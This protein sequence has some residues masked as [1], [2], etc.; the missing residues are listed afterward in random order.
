LE[1]EGKVAI[2]KEQQ[3]L[4]TRICEALKNK[5]II[6]ILAI[7]QPQ[8]GKTGCMFAT[9]KTYANDP[10]N[11]IPIENIHLI[12][13]LSSNDWVKQTQKRFP[14]MLEKNIYHRND[15]ASFVEKIR[16]K[17]NVLIIMDEVQVAAGDKQTLHK[18]FE[19]LGFLDKTTLFERDIKIVEFTAT[20]D[21]TIYDLMKW[22]DASYIEVADKCQGYMSGY[23][24]LN[25]RDVSSDK[26]LLLQE[27]ISNLIQEIA[28]RIKNGIEQKELDILN[29]KLVILQESER[30]SIRTRNGVRV[31]QFENLWGYDETTLEITENSFNAIRELK[32]DIDSFEEARFHIVRTPTKHPDAIDNFKK[33]FPAETYEFVHYDSK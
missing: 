13:G 21:G 31:K 8:S 5:S 23:D 22:G 18:T 19:S 1:E 26:I 7:A 28:N 33:Q 4:A 3:Q 29:K 32:A 11:Y 25:W 30:N 16:G 24:L 15:L 20:P 14:S 27:R 6:N 10:D 12:T 9:I 2:F 17:S